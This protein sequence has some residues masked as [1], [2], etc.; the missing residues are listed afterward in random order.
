M[1]PRQI[2]LIKKDDDDI[3]F[4]PLAMG[5]GGINTWTGIIPWNEIHLY[6][7]KDKPFDKASDGYECVI[8]EN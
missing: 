6:T 5:M 4:T 7:W 1:P 8:R 3:C 2:W